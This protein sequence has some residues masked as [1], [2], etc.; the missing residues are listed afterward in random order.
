VERI[1]PDKV[2]GKKKNSTTGWGKKGSMH[3]WGSSP[4][5][6][7][8]CT[9]ETDGFGTGEKTA[10]YR[11]EKEKLLIAIGKKYAVGGGG[12]REEK[13]GPFLG[14]GKKKDPHSVLRE[15]ISGDG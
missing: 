2:R 15:P 4:T 11:L 3:V 9:G 6:L 1:G 14:L 10:S 12:R 7:E 5:T 13:K 8:H